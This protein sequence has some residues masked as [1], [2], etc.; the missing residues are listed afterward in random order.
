MDIKAR[1]TVLWKVHILGIVAEAHLM[2]EIN[3]G[4]LNF[5]RYSAKWREWQ[6]DEKSHMN[7]AYGN[8]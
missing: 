1:Q 4:I 6:R 7:R 3:F 5:P 8:V 2:G